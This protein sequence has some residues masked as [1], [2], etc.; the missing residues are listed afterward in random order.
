VTLAAD[1]AQRRKMRVGVVVILLIGVTLV[2][3]QSSGMAGRQ[4]SELNRSYSAC[5]KNE[6]RRVDTGAA[7]PA[8]V[9]MAIWPTCSR[10]FARMREAVAH[11]E[12]ARAR[13]ELDSRFRL[14]DLDFATQMVVEQRAEKT[15]A[16]R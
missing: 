5:L 9:A 11:G 13:K 4:T 15:S 6:A 1:R 3:C 7:D 14:S 12:D 2:G 16:V 10:F 8:T